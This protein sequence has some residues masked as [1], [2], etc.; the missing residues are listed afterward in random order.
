[1][2]FDIFETAINFDFDFN[3]KLKKDNTFYEIKIYGMGLFS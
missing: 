2:N 1:M 3:E